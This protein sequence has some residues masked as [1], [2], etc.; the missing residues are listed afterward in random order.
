MIEPFLSAVPV[1]K[2]L[3]KAGFD[4]Y[5]VGGSVRDYLLKKPIHDVDIAT[6]ATPQEMKKIF[7]KTVDIGIEHGTILVLYRDASYEIT[8]FRTE[9]EYVDFRRPSS[10]S[11]IRSLQEDLMRRDFTMN[12]IAM[13]ANGKI[14]DPFFGQQAILDKRIETV[15]IAEERFQE[16]ALR[17]MRA[18]RFMSQL[19]FKIENKTL[20]ALSKLGFLLEKIAVERKTAE[21]EKL[22]LGKDRR[23]A[24]RYLIET[25]MFSFLPGLK[26]QK[27]SLT[28][29]Q[30]YSCENLNLNEMWSILIYCLDINGKTIENFLRGWKLPLK[31]IKEIGHILAFLHIRLER[32]WSR[33][34]LYLAKKDIFPSVEKIYLQIIGS[35]ERESLNKYNR[36]YQMLSIKDRAEMDITGSDL[37]NWFDQKGGPWVKEMLLKIEQ[38]ILDGEVENK[39]MKIKEWLMKCNQI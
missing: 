17:M 26:N 27:E 31:Q 9:A 12:A 11:Y 29:L 19:S 22:L 38:A 24:I 13:D 10:V 36:M 16:D 39:K 3:E 14:I 2:M 1:L 8:T 21:F 34:D 33:Y 20:N 5:F 35:D 15:G 7:S 37:M 4:A 30:T 18:V 28:K 6:S 25:N 23:K 32:E